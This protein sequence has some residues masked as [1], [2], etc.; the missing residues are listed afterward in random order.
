M[1]QPSGSAEPIK[2]ALP[3]IKRISA[4]EPARERITSVACTGAR[5]AEASRLGLQ[6]DLPF[7]AAVPRA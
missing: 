5:I 3:G 7:I 4:V 2:N 1:G 6:Q